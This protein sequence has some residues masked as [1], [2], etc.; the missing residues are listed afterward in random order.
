MKS[1][2]I[3]LSVFC[4][5]LFV[6]AQEQYIRTTDGVDLFVKVKGKG[7]PCLY[8]HGGPDSGSYWMEKFFGEILEQRF[9][10]IYLDQR[11]VC[12]SASP[13]DGNY[14]LDRMA[15]DYEEVRK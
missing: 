14:S 10:M 4:L 1:T 7:T 9:Q 3:I 2:F 6:Q 15:N 8:I 5:S 12:R 13:K 11:G